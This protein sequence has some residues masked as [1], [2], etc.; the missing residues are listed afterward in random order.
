[1]RAPVVGPMKAGELDAVLALLARLGLPVE[2]L[3]EHAGT[4][5]VAREHGG[6]IV[7]SAALEVYGSEA[8]LRSVAVDP[9]CQGLG[10]G[11]RLTEA[12]LAL[13]N[14]AGLSRVYLLTQ[15]AERFFPR[16]GFRAIA[17][18]DVPPSVRQSVEFRSA[19][20]ASAIAMEKRL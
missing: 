7:G 12:A 2:G 1:V 20:P 14:R 13:A 11:R 5:L 6:R 9:S 16:F 19:C 18:D 15:T 10:L 17:R 4:T 3:A 8:L